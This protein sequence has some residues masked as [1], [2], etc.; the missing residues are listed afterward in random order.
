MQLQAYKRNQQDQKQNGHQ[1][2]LDGNDLVEVV[3]KDAYPDGDGAAECQLDPAGVP[4]LAGNLISNDHRAQ[5]IDPGGNGVK[6]QQV[7]KSSLSAN[8]KVTPEQ[9]LPEKSRHHPQGGDQNCENNEDK[10]QRR[11]QYRTA[12][13][14]LA[15][16]PCRDR[17]HSIDHGPRAHGDQSANESNCGVKS[18]FTWREEMLHQDNIEVVDDG[19]AGEENDRLHPFEK[20]NGDCPRAEWGGTW[21]EIG[22]A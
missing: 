13:V 8:F 4:D 17:E 19:L 18:G 22:R 15:T 7:G 21:A 2:E 5:G 14:I 20:G 16:G 11:E 6:N 3:M 10:R 1:H 12:L 9:G